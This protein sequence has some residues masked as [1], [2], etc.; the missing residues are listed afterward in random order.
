MRISFQERRDLSHNQSPV[1]SPIGSAKRMLHGFQMNWRLW[2]MVLGLMSIVGCTESLPDYTLRFGLANSPTNLDPRYAT[3]ATSARL[4]RLLYSRLVDFG[5]GTIPIPALA[6]WRELSPI[7]YRFDLQEPRPLFHNG[8]R[9]SAN[10]VKATY[11]SILNPATASPHRGILQIITRIDTPTEN[12]VDFFL[13]RPDSLFPGYLVIGILPANLIARGYPFHDHPIGSGP[14]QFLERPDDTRLVIERQADGQRVEFLRI[15]DPTVRTLKLLANE[16]HL[17]QND[18]PPELVTY[19]SAHKAITLQQR[20][21]A[22]FAYLGFNQ[23]DPVVGQELVRKAIAHAID[24]EHIIQ[25]VLRG[26]ARVAQTLFPPE[27]WA[28]HASLSGYA[29]DPEEA[30]R[31][32]KEAGYDHD[33]RPT[34]TYKTSTDPFRLRLATIIQ[35]QLDQVG[36]DVSIQSHDWGTFY[37][38]IKSGR[39]QMYSLAWV[40]VKSPDIFRYAFHSDAIPPVGANRG[41]FAD[42][43]ADRLM[44]QAEQT[45]NRQEQQTLYRTLQARLLETLPYVPLWFE[46][47]YALASTTITGYQLSADGNFDGLSQVRWMGPPSVPPTHFARLYP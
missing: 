41:H 47:H 30:K 2:L 13:K 3:D 20:Q 24:R 9:L 39:F 12:T 26:R 29:Y 11:A 46:D 21:G 38:D 15:P 44:M 27:H 45:L 4:N 18:L 5:E 8:A 7:H 6:T 43:V 25:Y 28:G 33:H 32:L 34:I 14:F 31:L 40:G 37:G 10:D 36:I 16:I 42:V 22:N 17:L 1:C 19:L 35:Y 23:L